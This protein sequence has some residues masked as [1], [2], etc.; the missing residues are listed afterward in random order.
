MD[1]ANYHVDLLLQ[2][3][4]QGLLPPG[5]LRRALESEEFKAKA[6][7]SWAQLKERLK[8]LGRLPEDKE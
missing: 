7:E 8:E 5:M 1:L 4:E 6:P 3:E 2:M